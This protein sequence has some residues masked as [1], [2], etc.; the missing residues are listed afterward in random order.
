MMKKTGKFKTL[1]TLLVMAV[2]FL[3]TGITS[4]AATVRVSNL[5]QIDAGTTSVRVQYS[6]V[7]GYKYYGYQIASD[8]SFKSVIKYSYGCSYDS[9]ASTE[10]QSISDSALLK[11]GSTYYVRIGYGTSSSNC[12]NNWC[13]PIEVVTAPGTLS[14]VKFVSATDNSATIQ[15]SSEGANLYNIYDK[16]SGNLVGTTNKTSYTIKMTDSMSNEYRVEAVRKSKNGFSAAATSKKLVTVNLLT[17]KIDKK[18]FGIYNV[19]EY[20]NKI[21]VA[22]VFSGSGFE[23][24]LTNAG[25]SKYSNTESATKSSFTSKGTYTASFAYKENRYLKYRVRAYV[26]TDDGIKYGKWS[27]YRA[28][29]EM[30][31][32]Y[33]RGSKKVKFTWSKI[34]GSGKIKVQVSTKKSSKYKT[35]KTLKGTAKSVTVNK[36]GKST[37]KKNKKYY[38]KVT[39]MVKINGK[40]VA[41]DYYLQQQIKIK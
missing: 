31:G 32:K 38:F 28:F 36:Y 15:Y 4:E 3:V 20:I 35:F 34:K 23:V 27:D 12:Y 29:C 37:L 8:S 33:T 6:T 2:A 17:T 14:D 1:F 25:G 22:A 19:Y 18:N 10:T 7:S 41:S 40:Y 30:N 13:D 26:K 9:N 16:Y 39:P 5:T 11:Q 24:E 21:S